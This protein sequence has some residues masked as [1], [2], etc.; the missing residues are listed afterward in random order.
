MNW[1]TVFFESIVDPF[2]RHSLAAIGDSTDSI[3]KIIPVYA[4]CVIS[5]RLY[6]AQQ[7]RVSQTF[8]IDVCSSDCHMLLASTDESMAERKIDGLEQLDTAD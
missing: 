6:R 5:I 2:T 8:I 3:E 4:S 1:R 7:V